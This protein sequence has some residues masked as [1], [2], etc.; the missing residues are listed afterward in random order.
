MFCPEC[1][2]EIAENSNF[3]LEC[4]AEITE[5][6]PFREPNP[7]ESEIAS[8][9]VSDL[10]FT[11]IGF[12]SFLGGIL[13]HGLFERSCPLSPSEQF[14]FG[15]NSPAYQAWKEIKSGA[16]LYSLPIVFGICLTISGSIIKA[17]KIRLKKTTLFLVAAIS[18]II[19]IALIL[20]ANTPYME[21]Y[22]KF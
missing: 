3:C 7:K 19:A 13:I 16:L 14:M 2:K 15:N 6:V 4:G 11:I 10:V 12:L 1:G 17:A 20:Y 18:A 21:Y 9:R 22:R 5:R 8:P